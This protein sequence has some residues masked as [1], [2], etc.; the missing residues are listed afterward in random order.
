[1]IL[2]IISVLLIIS[3]YCS[4]SKDF[5]QIFTLEIHVI[6]FET[7][8]S[9]DFPDGN[10]YLDKNNMISELATGKSH[11]PKCELFIISF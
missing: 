10:Q 11:L 6:L 8:F 5:L 4:K 3:V 1:M 7:Y 2:C 9:V